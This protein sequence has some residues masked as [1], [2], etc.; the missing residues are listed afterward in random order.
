M[1]QPLVG[2]VCL[3]LGQASWAAGVPA[4]QEGSR[5][6]TRAAPFTPGTCGSISGIGGS[7]QPC[8]S[9]GV[10]P[11]RAGRAQHGRL[12]GLWNPTTHTSPTSPWASRAAPEAAGPTTSPSR[13]PA[14]ACRWQLLSMPSMRASCRCSVL[15]C[16]E[17]TA[18]LTGM[19]RLDGL[20]TRVACPA[21]ARALSV[22]GRAG[23][24]CRIPGRRRGKCPGRPCGRCRVPRAGA[25]RQ[26]RR[27]QGRGC[28]WAPWLCPGPAQQAQAQSPAAQPKQPCCPRQ[29]CLTS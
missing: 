22:A 9:A 19:Q 24:L 20:L 6:H 15:P 7:L 29:L 27:G 11:G 10:T 2:V 26:G 28:R 1:T 23:S 17:Q 14:G 16:P 18:H 4:Q 13:T 12:G 3:A 25:R 8:C 21:A 5:A